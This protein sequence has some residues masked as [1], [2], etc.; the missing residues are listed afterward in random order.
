MEYIQY[1]FGNI[2]FNLTSSILF[3]LIE[4]RELF[5]DALLLIQHDVA[6]RMISKPSTKEYGILS[7]ILNYFT[8]IKLEMKIPPNVF[9][10]KP[11][12]D[13]AIINV[14][15]NKE[16]DKNL[17][18]KFF[19]NVVKAS[20]G[21]RRKTLKNSLNN[22]IFVGYNLDDIQIDFS[23]RAETLSVEEFIYL[24][25]ELQKKSINYGRK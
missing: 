17:N 10:P 11:R 16:I 25:I 20:F 14:K 8:T 21:N 19:I 7:V 5:S 4:E 2:P 13:S 15:F 24:A 6:K 9:T 22:S 12:V 1:L 23:R 18:D 3:N